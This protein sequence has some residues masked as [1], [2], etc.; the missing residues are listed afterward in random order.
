M[1]IWIELETDGSRKYQMGLK[2]DESTP[3]YVI[4]AFFDRARDGALVR[5]AGRDK[6]WTVRQTDEV[7]EKTPAQ[8]AE[9][10]AA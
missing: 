8:P 7:D 3:E 5:A 10:Q 6:T 1:K 9:E 4:R 2:V